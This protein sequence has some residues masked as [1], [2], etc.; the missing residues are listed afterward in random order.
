[1]GFY[2]NAM[3]PQSALQQMWLNECNVAVYHMKEKI[4]IKFSLAFFNH[5][6]EIIEV[7]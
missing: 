7:G 4:Q 6:R 3:C 5:E 1:M 2:C